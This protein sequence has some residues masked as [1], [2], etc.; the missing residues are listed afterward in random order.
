[1]GEVG[2]LVEMKGGSGKSSLNESFYI[3]VK[4]WEPF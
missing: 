2:A 4:R 1:M 3:D